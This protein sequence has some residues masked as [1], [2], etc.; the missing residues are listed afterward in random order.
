MI[1]DK[2]IE[3]E[4]RMVEEYY[5]QKKAQNDRVGSLKDQLRDQLG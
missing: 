2:Q 3:K 1:V 4:S 5:E